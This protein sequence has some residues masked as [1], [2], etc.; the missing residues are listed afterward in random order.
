[1]KQSYTYQENDTKIKQ[2][3]HGESIDGTNQK[4]YGVLFVDEYPLS[5]YKESN[6]QAKN[7]YPKGLR[8]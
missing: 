2:Y 1:M 5:F 6:G 7:L 8:R 4:S 3:I